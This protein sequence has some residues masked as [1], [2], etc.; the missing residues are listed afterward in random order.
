MRQ[1]GIVLFVVLGLLLLCSLLVAA[2]LRTAIV[3]EMVV[4]NDSD[5]QGAFAL[6]Q[7]RLRDAE[8]AIRGRD[9]A[10]ED[11]RAEALRLPTGAESFEL[12]S[13]ALR[14][15]KPSCDA[16]LCVPEGMQSYFWI[17]D[18][19]LQAMKKVAAPQSAAARS[20]RWQSWYWVELLAYDTS[21]ALEGGRA[22]ALSPDPDAPYIYRVTAIAEGRKPSTRVVLQTT[23]VRKK[24]RS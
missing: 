8:R 18:A 3:D 2:T 10:R 15:A 23:L 12:L 14:A 16:G 13:T 20:G 9:E 21:A 1:K 22:E 17:D 11:G 19:A 7:A 6:A 24:S 4:G 5:R